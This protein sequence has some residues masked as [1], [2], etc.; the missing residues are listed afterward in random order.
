MKES[1]PHACRGH[2]SGVPDE[3]SEAPYH[4]WLRRMAPLLVLGE[5]SAW[6][7]YRS[8]RRVVLERSGA[9]DCRDF[10]PIEEFL[11]QPGDRGS[12]CAGLGID[13]SCLD[14]LEK[15]GLIRAGEGMPPRY[16]PDDLVR[17]YWAV[18]FFREMALDSSGV[19]TLL[20]FLGHLR[21]P[22]ALGG[23]TPGMHPAG[24][25]A[26]VPGSR[27][28]E[29][30]ATPSSETAIERL[31]HDIGTPLHVIGGRADLLKRKLADSEIA[32]RNLSIIQEQ[33]QRII[34]LVNNY[35]SRTYAG[36]EEPEPEAPIEKPAAPP[37]EAPQEDATQ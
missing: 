28:G 11:A 26:G 10:P 6:A 24:G 23:G 30:T 2:H 32:V 21:A 19:E 34:A 16:P 7:E 13:P 37:H 20:W 3:T 35:R 33:V 5:P 12:I 36:H 14:H 25:P 27:S 1:P 29:A 17:I 9:A 31:L 4:A 8:R 22:E 15:T 18:F